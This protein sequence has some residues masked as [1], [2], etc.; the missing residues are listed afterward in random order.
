MIR[1]FDY[2]VEG[3]KA[4]TLYLKDDGTIDTKFGDGHGVWVVNNPTT[5]VISF[6]NVQHTVVFNL[7]SMEATQTFPN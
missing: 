2:M 1:E 4:G 7:K 6:Q 3:H 5:A